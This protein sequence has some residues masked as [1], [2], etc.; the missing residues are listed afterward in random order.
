MKIVTFTGKTPS[1]AYKKAKME[2]GDEGLLIETREIRKKALGRDGLFEIVIGLDEDAPTQTYEKPAKPLSK[3]KPITRESQE[4]LFDIS[5]AAKQISEISN[6]TE[7]QFEYKKPM[8]QVT[9]VEPKE[10]KEIKSEIN[11]LGDK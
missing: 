3:Q 11:K 2:I 10:L 7:P 6:V 5:N 4:I 1:E 9:S 8:P